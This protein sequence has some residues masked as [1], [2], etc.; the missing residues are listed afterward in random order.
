MPLTKLAR[1]ARVRCH[2]AAWT[3]IALCLAPPTL[4][5]DPPVDFQA[6]T[7]LFQ[8]P[9]IDSLA[10]LPG[11]FVEMQYTLG[12]LDR[13][14]RLQTRINEMLRRG[15]AAFQITVY[16]L[17]RDQW[18]GARFNMP[19]GIPVRVGPSGLAV[20]ASGDAGTAELWNDL[21]VPLPSA[22][23]IVYRGGPGHAPSELMADVVA[24]AL[25]GEIYADLSRLAGDEF[26]LR[27]L[28]S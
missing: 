3:L 9:A 1:H 8:T 19:Y 6:P 24:L 4:A 10:T 16:V 23:G 27:G 11:D 22:P 15:D 25:A 28:V 12:A 2:R 17:N 13:A 7:R 18:S 21:Q 20:P 14:A 26:W 5:E